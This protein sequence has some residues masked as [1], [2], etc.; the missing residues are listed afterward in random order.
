MKF[1]HNLQQV[2]ILYSKFSLKKFGGYCTIN[3]MGPENSVYLNLCLYV[4]NLAVSLVL[5]LWPV[6]QNFTAAIWLVFIFKI[7]N[8]YQL[9]RLKLYIAEVQTKMDELQ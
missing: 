9:W 2:H 7:F 4:P 5:Y 1:Q 8:S 3:M 6:G